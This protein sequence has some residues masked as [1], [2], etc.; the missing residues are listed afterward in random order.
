[1]MVMLPLISQVLLLHPMVLNAQALSVG[2]A[3]RAI[4][5]NRVAR[6]FIWGIIKPFSSSTSTTPTTQVLDES[7]VYNLGLHPVITN[8]KMATQLDVHH[9]ATATLRAGGGGANV[10]TAPLPK[11]RRVRV[12][13]IDGVY[14]DSVVASPPSVPRQV[15][16]EQVSRTT[17]ESVIGSLVQPFQESLDEA[18]GEINLDRLIAA[19]RKY[20]DAVYKFGQKSMGE[21]LKQNLQNIEQAKAQVPKEHQTTLRSLLEYEKTMGVRQE[22]GKLRERSAALSFLWIRRS[23]AFQDHLNG[24][25]VEHPD[26]PAPKAAMEAY[27]QEIQPYHSWG[28]QKVFKMG[29][30]STT[31]P[32]SKTLAQLRGSTNDELD[33]AE[34]A[35]TIQDLRSLRQVFQPLLREWKSTFESLDLEDDSKA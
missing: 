21:N 16:Q 3:T 17:A 35:K 20:T 19:C 18:H 27:E 6:T 33:E 25:L 1:M 24:I 4:A 5:P 26:L 13:H 12:R 23:L 32:R 9:M 22:G 28:L 11:Q 2:V 34:E 30:R 8:K 15:V 7:Q 29:L 10:L 14:Y 31:P